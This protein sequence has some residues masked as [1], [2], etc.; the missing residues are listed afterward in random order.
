MPSRDGVRNF[1]RRNRSLA[2]QENLTLKASAGARRRVSMR[3][4]LRISC[5]IPPRSGASRLLRANRLTADRKRTASTQSHLWG[6]VMKGRN[7]R[8]R[9]QAIRRCAILKI[10]IIPPVQSA[11]H[12][13]RLFASCADFRERGRPLLPS[14]LSGIARP[15]DCRR[16]TGWP[17][18]TST[19]STTTCAP[20]SRASNGRSPLALWSSAWTR[21]STSDSGRSRSATI[22][23]VVPEPSAPSA[24]FGF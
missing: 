11:G 14:S 18:S 22:T 12:R 7:P 19:A 15:F 8:Q 5:L 23:A 6:L 3:S 4:D 9:S 1:S 10:A 13:W 24:S 21:F 20:A 17:L 2:A 16:T